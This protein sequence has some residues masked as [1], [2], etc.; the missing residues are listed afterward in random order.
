[1]ARID[2]AGLR[3][4][5]SQ[6]YPTLENK[7]SDIRSVVSTM[8]SVCQQTSNT[9]A[10]YNAFYDYVSQLKIPALQSEMVFVQSFADAIQS[11]LQALSSLQ[12]DASGIVDTDSI[13]DNISSIMQTNNDLDAWADEY[14]D[15]IPGASW[16]I[17]GMKWINNMA[18][19]RLNGQLQAAYDYLGNT[20]IYAAAQGC[21]GRAESAVSAL[22]QAVFNA[23]TGTY[24]LSR[25]SDWSWDTPELASAYDAACY[26]LFARRYFNL[27]EDGNLTPNLTA[28]GRD[29]LS[30]LFSSDMQTMNTLLGPLVHDAERF[31]LATGSM[32]AQ[33]ASYI[34]GDL[35]R[36]YQS[37]VTLT[38]L[39]PIA[40]IRSAALDFEGA[41]GQNVI[42][43]PVITQLSSFLIEGDELES[44][45]SPISL[46]Y[47]FGF[48]DLF[49][50]ASSGAAMN[51]NT[52]IATYNYDGNEYRLQLWHGGYIAGN[53]I[54]GEV[55]LYYRSAQG[56]SQNPYVSGD[57]LSPQEMLSKL[58]TM[59][60]AQVDSYFDNYKCVPEGK[61]IP[62]DVKIMSQDGTPIAES[63]SATHTN[64]GDTYWDYV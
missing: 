2:V 61:Q 53:L 31:I 42:Y 8:S 32:F 40:G 27:D 12:P 33:G 47:L 50:V 26:D 20:S 17:D 60:D 37:L 15:V 18:I 52:D 3:D 63:N 41:T 1:M 39:D 25:V 4:A 35:N 5:L 59:S 34:E 38:G 21:A 16:V 23:D 64:N 57:P 48:E 46:Q 56:A 43:I 10:A 51:L 55:G 30:A 45:D 11:D 7:A 9:S 13:S 58:P 44:T 49:D 54:G 28:A 29:M 24:D 19:D 6:D 36:L 22:H 62:M 14:A